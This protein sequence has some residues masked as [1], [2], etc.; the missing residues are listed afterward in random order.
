MSAE[1]LPPGW[2]LRPAVAADRDLLVALERECFPQDAFSRRQIAYYLRHSLPAGRLQLAI[3]CAETDMAVGALYLATPRHHRTAR[4][5]SVAVRPPWQ[6]QGIGALL[7]M[8]AERRAAAQGYRRIVAETRVENTASRT[9]LHRRG[10]RA[11]R[12]LP[13]YYGPGQDGVKWALSLATGG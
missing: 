1:A 13:N 11:L 7:V 3:V 2:R 4:L 8:E 5:F 10:W 12:D 9:L 6:R